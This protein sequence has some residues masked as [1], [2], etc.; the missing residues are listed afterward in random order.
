M[1]FPACESRTQVTPFFPIGWYSI[2]RSIELR[3]GE[4]RPITVF[5]RE[6]AL[7]R[8]RTGKAMVT[9]AFCP[10][11]GAHLGVNGRVVGEDLRC[12]FHGWK[13]D[14]EGKCN[15][16]PYCDEI[17]DRAKIRTWH[18]NESNGDI[19]VWFHPEDKAPTFENPTIE[20]LS[21]DDWSQPQY[22]EFT[23]PNH[24]QNIAENVCDPEH[25]QYVHGMPDTPPSEVTIDDDGRIL[26]LL[27]DAKDADHPNE[28]RATVFNPGH[29]I[30][31]T[32]YGPGAEM[33]LYSTAQPVSLHE[34][35][36]RW[37]LTVRK[38]IVDFAG[39]DVMRGIKA[40]IFDDMHIWEHKI[41]R[42]KPLFCKADTTLV[43]FRKW[44]RQFYVDGMRFVESESPKPKTRFIDA[45]AVE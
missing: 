9:D 39:D 11:L 40:G 24:V 31:R 34:T 10:H 41:Y 28:L 37:T 14:A 44:V 33:L 29:A 3:D 27:T 22:W 32:T 19:M 25:F 43:Q 45:R 20:E 35:H 21:H 38:E 15:E 7:Y 30:V 17:P 23:V 1:N 5:D 36:M 2:A 18:V 16:I 4:V 8:S 42:E 12:P 13:F 26:H 6:L